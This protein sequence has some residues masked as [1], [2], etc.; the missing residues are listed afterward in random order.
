ME[1]V[2]VSFVANGQAHFIA[3]SARGAVREETVMRTIAS[4]F[5]PELTESM[6]SA[7]DGA[8]PKAKQTSAMKVRRTSPKAAND[9]RPAWPLLPFPADWFATS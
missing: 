4:I 6:K 8:A 5:E 9:N 3:A 1:L 2:L 7:L